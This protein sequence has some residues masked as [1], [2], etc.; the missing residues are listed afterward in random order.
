MLS[1][2][3]RFSAPS[4]WMGGGLV[5]RCVGHVYSAD[6]AVHG[7]IRTVH[8][9]YVTTYIKK[10]TLLHQVGISNYFRRQLYLLHS[11]LRMCGAVALY[12]N[13]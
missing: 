9:T 3:I 13:T 1:C 6:G 7:T 4:F 11:C 12:S 2:R 10:N 5:S 8:T